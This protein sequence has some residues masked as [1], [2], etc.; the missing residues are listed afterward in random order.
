MNVNGGLEKQNLEKFELN[1]KKGKKTNEG[2]LNYFEKILT[3][4]LDNSIKVNVLGIF[5]KQS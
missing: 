5:L 3:Y 1:Y 4:E 2:S